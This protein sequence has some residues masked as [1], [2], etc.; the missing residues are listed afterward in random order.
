VLESHKLTEA[1]I[2]LVRAKLAAVNS[3]QRDLQLHLEGLASGLGLDKDT[4]WN[5]NQDTWT[6]EPKEEGK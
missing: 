6:F 1:Q 5:L 3:F 4:Q 2:G